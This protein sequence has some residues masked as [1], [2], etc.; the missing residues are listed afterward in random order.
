MW[1]RFEDTTPLPFYAIEP[2]PQVFPVQLATWT[3]EIIQQEDG[4]ESF[5][6]F[7]SYSMEYCALQFFDD[8]SYKYCGPMDFNEE[9]V[10]T[11]TKADIVQYRRFVSKGYFESFLWRMANRYACGRLCRTGPC[12]TKRCGCTR[13][14]SLGCPLS[15]SISGSSVPTPECK[16][17]PS[18]TTSSPKIIQREWILGTC[19][20]D[21]GFGSTSKASPLLSHSSFRCPLP[22]CL[23]ISAPPT[24]RRTQL[25]R[26]ASFRISSTTCLHS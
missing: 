26:I 25:C 6:L 2:L 20:L 4:P 11:A 23:S 1:N 22:A 5:D 8:D 9:I 15:T 18:T 7:A 13:T 21:M 12:Q 24:S 14:G 10:E 17:I 3:P 16:P 19:I